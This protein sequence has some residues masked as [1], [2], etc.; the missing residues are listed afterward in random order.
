MKAA[1]QWTEH[2]KR[3]PP[4]RV[5]DHVRIQN[6]TGLHPTKWDKTGV[7]IQVRQFDQYNV[8]IDGSSRVTLRNRKFLWQYV[9]VQTPP[10]KRTVDDDLRHISRPLFQPTATPP[11]LPSRA[12]TLAAPPRDQLPAPA[13]GGPIAQATPPC[14]SYKTPPP[15]TPSSDVPA[16]PLPTTAS[17][18]TAVTS[19]PGGQPPPKKPPLAVRRLLDYKKNGLLELRTVHDKNFG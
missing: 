8:R 5:G 15:V 16:S 9:P 1:E 17:P 3:L 4:L 19:S 2:T 12:S 18:T 7:V 6:Q 11:S 14:P 10:P 13:T